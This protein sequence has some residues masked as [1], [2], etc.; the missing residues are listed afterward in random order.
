MTDC[1]SVFESRFLSGLKF[2]FSAQKITY[3]V[4]LFSKNPQN[5][6]E[7]DNLGL[8]QTYKSPWKQYHDLDKHQIESSI[9]SGMP[10]ERS[11]YIITR[12]GT[13][14][15]NKPIDRVRA[16]ISLAGNFSGLVFSRSGEWDTEV[17]GVPTG[18]EITLKLQRG[19]NFDYLWVSHAVPPPQLLRLDAPVGIDQSFPQPV[20][21]IA[22]SYPKALSP[23]P[24]S[25]SNVW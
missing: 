5:P 17:F 21:A 14:T 19:E 25:C 7:L 1:I 24:I 15:R 10:S 16:Y 11:G 18:I 2:L 4:P 22:V 8:Q 23:I 12:Y 13:S 6:E 9:P 3:W 20:V